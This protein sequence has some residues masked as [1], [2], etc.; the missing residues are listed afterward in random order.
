MGEKWLGAYLS[1]TGCTTS[2]MVD[3]VTF[4]V[5]GPDGTDEVTVPVGL[6]EQ[7]SEADDE[8]TAQVVADIAITSFAQRAHMIG[9]HGE[10]EV[11]PA[12][13]A[14]EEAVLDRFEERFGL[15]FGEATGHQH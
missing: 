4:T 12:F 14:L 3:E 9:H 15:T 8:S 11:D 2:P 10:G 7:L 1:M 13:D 6:V 5:E